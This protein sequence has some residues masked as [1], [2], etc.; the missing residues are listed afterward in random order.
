MAANEPA[1][2]SPRRRLVPATQAQLAAAVGM[3]RPALSQV[4]KGLVERGWV[5]RV[6]SE[7]DQRSVRVHL[8]ASGRQVLAATAGRAVGTLQRAVRQL[9]SAELKGLAAGIEK[10]LLCLRE[11]TD[12]GRHRPRVSARLDHLFFKAL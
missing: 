5:E 8:T 1:Q 9:S 4:L 6:R 10:I 11:P 2:R 12:I 7:S 3:H